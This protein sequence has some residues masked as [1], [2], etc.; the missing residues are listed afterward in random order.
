AAVVMIENAH[1]HIEAWNH[2]HPDRRP[3]AAEQAR[4]IAEAA[5]EVGPALF[6][7]LLIITLSFLPVFTLEAQEGKLFGPLAF[8]KT[9]SMAAA[10]ALSVTLIPVLM[11]YFVRGRI[12]DERSNP[13]NRIL[14]FVYRPLLDFALRHP[15]AILTASVLLMVAA[16]VPLTKLGSEFMPPLVEG[17]LLYMPSAL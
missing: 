7:S 6:F 16:I 11:F 13:I 10:A 9:Y 2:E 15:K 8:T 12:P 3:T 1:K 14:I 17:D 4:L 5:A